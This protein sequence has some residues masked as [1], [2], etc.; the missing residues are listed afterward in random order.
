MTNISDMTVSQYNRIGEETAIIPRYQRERRYSHLTDPKINKDNPNA[1][2][3]ATHMWALFRALIDQ[4]PYQTLRNMHKDMYIPSTGLLPS[5]LETARN[6]VYRKIKNRWQYKEYRLFS[7]IENYFFPELTTICQ[8]CNKPDILLYHHW[9]ED[10]GTKG[11]AYICAT[12]NCFLQPQ[13]FGNS[14]SHHLPS[15]EVQEK[16][17]LTQLR[18]RGID[19]AQS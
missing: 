9:I 10:D 17:V 8:A 5:D 7:V 19:Y 15:W 16:Y 11:N 1:S 13:R 14:K 4:A 12:C 6:Y 2:I 18:A 3:L